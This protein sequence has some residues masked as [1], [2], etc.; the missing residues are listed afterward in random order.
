MIDLP[1]MAKLCDAR[2]DTKL[3]LIGDAAQLAPV[4]GGAVFNGLINLLNLMN[5]GK[6]ICQKWELFRFCNVVPTKQSTGRSMIQLSNI[7]RRNIHP[8]GR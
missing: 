4:H 7:H 1:L 6:R 3:V 5:F 8:P 2:E